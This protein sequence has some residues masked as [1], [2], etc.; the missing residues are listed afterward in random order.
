MADSK[1]GKI[2]HYYDKIGVAVIEVEKKLSVGDKIKFIKGKE[3][4]FEQIVASMENEH[5]KVNSAK[6]GESVGMKVDQKVGPG[7]GV[8]KID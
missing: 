2:S 8:Y 3:D 1:V 7:I 6:K 5:Q 4:L